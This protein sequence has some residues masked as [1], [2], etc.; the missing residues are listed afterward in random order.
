VRQNNNKKERRIVDDCKTRR[1]RGKGKERVD[2]G[3]YN[4]LRSASQLGCSDSQTLK[5]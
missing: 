5:Y 3:G 2:G 4:N 1:R